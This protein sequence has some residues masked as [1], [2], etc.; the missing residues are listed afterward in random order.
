MPVNQS[1][2]YM[3]ERDFLKHLE[4]HRL[5]VFTTSDAAKITG[6]SGRN[7][8]IFLYR[9]EKRKVISRLERG[10]YHLTKIP[11]EIIAS[12]IISPSYISFL[13]ALSHHN[14]QENLQ[15]LL[16][17][18]QYPISLPSIPNYNILQE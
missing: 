18:E 5:G 15:F 8:N 4:L 7:L 6:S 1:R 3:K 9:L 13:S 14:P 2:I 11:V 12:E 17:A 10:K 16:Y